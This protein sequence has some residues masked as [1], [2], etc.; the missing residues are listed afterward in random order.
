MK[1][2]TGN[3]RPEGGGGGRK[4]ETVD[5]GRGA[6]DG[7]EDRKLETG[8]LRPETGDLRPETGEMKPRS[9][10]KF[11]SQ[12]SGFTSQA[13]SPAVFDAGGL[14]FTPEDFGATKAEAWMER[15]GG[16]FGNLEAMPALAWLAGDAAEPRKPSR[17]WQVEVAP[18]SPV[19]IDFVAGAGL[20]QTK[21]GQ[22]YFLATDRVN[23]GE[24]RI[25]NFGKEAISGRLDLG[26]PARSGGRGVVDL[27]LAAGE[28]RVLPVEFPAGAAGIA[29][30][31]WQ[32]G[33]RPENGGAVGR[34]Q[35]KLH[36]WPATGSRRVVR[37][38]R[39]AEAG[40]E[41]ARRLATRPLATHEPPET[42]ANGWSCTRGVTVTETAD[43]WSISMAQLP[44]EPTRPVIAEL[45]L[46]D[47][48]RLEPEQFVDLAY[49][50]QLNG[51]GDG[52]PPTGANSEVLRNSMII[53]WRTA[54][55]NL[56]TVWRPSPATEKWQ[57]YAQRAA[58]FTMGFYGRANLPWRFAENRP[59][60]LVF[61]ILP[62]A[63]P[64]TL[65]VRR[66]EIVGY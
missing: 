33:F 8:A 62:G 59:V 20:T 61:M 2:E 66:A 50:V 25:Y 55:G 17:S 44:A 7:A 46:P 40:A 54:N 5:R 31:V 49:R 28:L 29:T 3:L 16:R 19:V 22:G 41:N 64:A 15:I 9:G 45:I 48:F 21:Q 10:G 60:S 32:L 65:E 34:F 23:A 1:Y 4:G 26:G 35:T 43:M 57:R 53:A 63:L 11:G 12:V 18:P 52:P 47:D 38:L 51:A 6:V 14:T 27:T 13:S 36:G 39:G 56:Y 37:L 42:I 30:R 58:S 24:V